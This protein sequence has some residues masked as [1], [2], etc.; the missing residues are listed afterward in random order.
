MD[1]NSLSH[2]SRALSPVHTTSVSSGS[3]RGKHPR[4]KDKVMRQNHR[5]KVLSL[6]SR[7]KSG[8]SLGFDDCAHVCPNERRC[9][10]KITPRMAECA[11]SLSYGDTVMELTGAS[12]DAEWTAIQGSHAMNASVFKDA[13]N[14]LPVLS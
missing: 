2:P 5:T 14:P 7:V 4:S 6:V 3:M 1:N 13:L 9:A 12:E 8:H 10:K 11:L